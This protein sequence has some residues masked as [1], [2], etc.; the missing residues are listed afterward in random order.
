M[1]QGGFSLLGLLFLVAGLGVAMAAVGTVWETAARREKERELLF[2]GNQF[3]QALA[4]YSRHTP[5][6]QPI[7]PRSLD[8]LLLDPRFPFTL[9]HLRRVYRDPITG[10]VDWGLVKVDGTIRAVYSPSTE[11][12]LKRSGFTGPDAAFDGA[13]SY[14]KWVFGNEAGGA[15]A[16]RELDPPDRADQADE[17]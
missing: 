14:A 12:P 15:S 9:R 5:S 1:R 6:G 3:R 16:T 7:Y 10:M 4:S 2:I 8:E 17:R 13:S 11:P